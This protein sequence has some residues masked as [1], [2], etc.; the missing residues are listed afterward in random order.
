MGTASSALRK[1][2]DGS[3]G[4]ASPSLRKRRDGARPPPTAVSTACTL[5]EP[6]LNQEQRRRL[7]KY[8]RPR[9][10]AASAGVANMIAT[11]IVAFRFPQHFWIWHMVK[12]LILLPWRFVRFRRRKLQLYMLDWCYMVT[13][14]INLGAAAAAARVYL[15]VESAAAPYN[16]EIIRAGFAMATGPLAWSVFAFRNSLVMH[17]VD[18]ITSVFIH[19]SPMALLWCLRWGAGMGPS[20]TERAWPGL[21]KVCPDDL[22][23][24]DK[25]LSWSR[26]ALWCD[27]CPARPDE[28]VVAPTVIYVCVW[29]IP[30]FLIMFVLLR[31]WATRT[32]H[33][34]LFDYFSSA[35]P[36]LV[37]KLDATFRPWFGEL[38]APLGYMGM[39]LLSV[40]TLGAASYVFW[41]SF[42]AHTAFCVWVTWCAVHN[43]SRYTFRRFAHFHVLQ[44]AKRHPEIMAD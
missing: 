38:G 42:V 1:R 24:A 3:M 18:N 9:E 22:A 32:G 13:H 36:A 35:Q 15:G 34:M 20:I 7:D 33:E 40:L 10:A 28:F 6:V 30:Y 12:T 29:A 14:M 2:R 8:N 4:G 44:E 16:K 19:F 5:L 26:D 31:D 37:A 41:H 27:A 23:A 21:F 11:A 17:D 39:H 25:C 43:G